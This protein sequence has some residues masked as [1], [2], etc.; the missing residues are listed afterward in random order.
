MSRTVFG[1]PVEELAASSSSIFN[2]G[3]DPG[4]YVLKAG[5]TMTG[6]LDME[7]NARINIATGGSLNTWACWYQ[8]YFWWILGGVRLLLPEQSVVAVMHSHV[9]L[10]HHQE[11]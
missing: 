1:L 3:F 6:S 5:D 10:K 4:D 9:N 8:F 11:Q 2:I 7:N